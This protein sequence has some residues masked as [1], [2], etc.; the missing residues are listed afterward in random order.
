MPRVCSTSTS[1]PAASGCSEPGITVP[2]IGSF[3]TVVSGETRRGPPPSST[4]RPYLTSVRKKDEEFDP[5]LP[6]PP[7]PHPA[8]SSAAV[9]ARSPSDPA[10]TA[11]R[12]VRG[13]AAHMSR[14]MG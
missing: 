1:T 11:R 5:A 13:V 8:A 3:A 9:P 10:A 14:S 12:I 7:P 4:R 2:V 6:P